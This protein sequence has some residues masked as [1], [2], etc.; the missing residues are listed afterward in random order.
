LSPTWHVERDLTDY[1]AL[2]G[3]AQAG[4]VNLGNLVDST[5]TGIITGSAVLKLYP[6]SAAAPAPRAADAVLPLSTAPGGAALLATT[7]SVLAPT[8]TL[9]TNVEAAYLDLV[10]QSQSSD[11]FWYTCV[12]DDVAG[13]LFSCPGTAFREAEVTIDG[14]P[15]GVAPVYPWIY[16]GGIDPFL[17]R[18]IPGVQTLDFLPYRV[19]LTPFAGLLS[20][21]RPHQVGVAVFNADNYFLVAASLLLYLDHGASRVTGAVTENTL[22]AAPQPAIRK[23]LTTAADGTVHATVTTKSERQ[24]TLAGYVNTSHG[25]IQTTLRQAIDFSN[26]QQLVVGATQYVQNITQG[27]RIS[28]LTETKGRGAGVPTL[29][30]KQLSYPLTLSFSSIGNADG[31]G[32]QTTT[33][34]QRFESQEAEAGHGSPSFDVVSNAVATTDTLLFDAAGNLT[35]TQ[36][37]KSSQAYKSQGNGGCYSRSIASTDGVLTSLVDGQ[38]CSHHGDR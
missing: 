7:A 29:A 14:Q 8:F 19:D 18:P 17:W 13:E 23:D 11:E 12:P 35:G 3:T 20:N 15:A 30:A 21:G 37:Q 10:T 24:F 6:A 34:D 27:T 38:G 25:K 4:D 22:A 28:S 5:Y 26:R 31:S 1:G 9:P 32:A 2:L 33:I 16:T 36:D